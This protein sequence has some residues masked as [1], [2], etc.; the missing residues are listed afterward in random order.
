M[1]GHLSV[2]LLLNIRPKPYLTFSRKRFSLEFTR[3]VC[4]PNT[5]PAASRAESATLTLCRLSCHFALGTGTR[6]Q[7]CPL[8]SPR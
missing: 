8:P 4:P 1:G 2:F 5:Q 7:G 3:F 6:V